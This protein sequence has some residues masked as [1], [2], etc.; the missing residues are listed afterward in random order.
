MRLTIGWFYWTGKPYTTTITIRNR[1]TAAPTHS[2]LSDIFTAT[3]ANS[4]DKH[5]HDDENN[6][7]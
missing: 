2:L 5:N 7:S 1:R 4:S 3:I 6:L